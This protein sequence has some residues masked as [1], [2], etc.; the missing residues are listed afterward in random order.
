MARRSL[1][2]CSDGTHLVHV[3]LEPAITSRCRTGDLLKRDCGPRGQS[4]E[5]LVSAVKD[6]GERCVCYSVY[7]LW[8]LTSVF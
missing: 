6:E 2:G 3:Q 8:L 7:V 4:H 5:G 1:C